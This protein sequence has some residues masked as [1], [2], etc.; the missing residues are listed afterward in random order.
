MAI[1]IDQLPSDLVYNGQLDVSNPVKQAKYDQLNSSYG[2]NNGGGGSTDSG[3][4]MSQ[5]PSVQNFVQDQFKQE[6]PYLKALTSRMDSREKP[7]DVYKRI[8]AEQGL[9][10]LRSASKTLT[11]QINGIED[12]LDQIEPNVAARSRE[13]IITEAQRARLVQSEK[14]PL[15]QRLGN[16]T[17]D[18]GRIGNTITATNA[19]VGNLVN[20]TQQGDEQAMESLKLVYSTVVDRNTRTLT[21]F[22][23][24]RQTLLDSL[25][26]KL[27][28]QR[29]LDDREWQ[30]AAELDKEENGYIK[31]LQTAAVNL[32]IN[33]GGIS[34]PNQ[35]LALIGKEQA[36]NVALERKD[37]M[38]TINA[39]GAANENP[40]TYLN[41]TNKMGWKIVP[42][43]G[44]S[45]SVLN[46]PPMSAKAGTITEYPKGSGMI[47]TSNGN[48][49]N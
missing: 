10:E 48:G 9:P 17:R 20:L 31:T 11:Q 2:D 46:S 28:R 1:P 15:Q 49:W 18:L 30:L 7:I 39:R 8:S 32:G 19:E 6:D 33:A 42:A 36:V 14:E 22:T 40:N 24:D 3:I 38:S 13:S 25:Y 5:V 21:G 23:A 47:W 4:D 43:E 27:T 16:Y 37:K 12:Y 44:K 29:Q 45:N 34:D 41:E 26:D 35:L